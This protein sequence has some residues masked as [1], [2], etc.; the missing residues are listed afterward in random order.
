MQRSSED[1]LIKL[2]VTKLEYYGCIKEN[3]MLSCT[4]S[5]WKDTYKWLAD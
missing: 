4:E 2:Q 5:V 3:D 1:W